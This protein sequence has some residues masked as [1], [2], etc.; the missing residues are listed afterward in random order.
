LFSANKVARRLRLTRSSIRH[1]ATL[2]EKRNVRT[3]L[4][5]TVGALALTGLLAGCATE[6]ATNT[7]TNT[8]TTTNAN[9]ANAANTTTTTTTTTAT[10]TAPDNSEIVTTEAGGTRVETRT[11]RNNPRV[12]RVVVRTEPSGRRTATVYTTDNRERDLPEGNIETALDATGSAIA[13]AAGFVVDKAGDV[14][15]AAVDVGGTVI[16]KT[17]EGAKKVGEVTV[18]GAKTAGE[19]TAD[20]AKTVGKKTVE[21][22]KTVGSKTVK[23]A[24][25]VGGAVKDAV[26]P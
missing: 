5:T 13:D 2:K 12:S 16:E 21:G 15:G 23:G 3:Q 11:F 1:F 22:A 20:G 9:N 14:G 18:D 19:K 6:T 17:G 8:A 10:R 4:L 26:T 7:N 24:K 25:K